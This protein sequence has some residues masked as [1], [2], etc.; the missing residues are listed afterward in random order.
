MQVSPAL[1]VHV[2]FISSSAWVCR[3]MPQGVV[4]LSVEGVAHVDVHMLAQGEP[5][6]QPHDWSW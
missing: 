6:A 3:H 4:E 5:V 2:E 1:V